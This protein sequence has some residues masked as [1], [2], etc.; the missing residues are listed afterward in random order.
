MASH[1]PHALLSS[2]QDGTWEWIPIE[3]GVSQGCHAL[4]IFAATVLKHILEKKYSVK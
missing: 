2:Y 1:V 3:E 4:P